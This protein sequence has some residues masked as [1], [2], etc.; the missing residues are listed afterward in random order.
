MMFPVVTTC[1]IMADGWWMFVVHQLLSQGLVPHKPSLQNKGRSTTRPLYIY[2]YDIC[3]YIHDICV[4]LHIYI[5]I[6]ILYT[7]LFHVISCCFM[8]GNVLSCCFHVFVCVFCVVSYLSCLTATHSMWIHVLLC[9]FWIHVLL[10]VIECYWVLS[11]PC[12]KAIISRWF[13]EWE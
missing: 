5:Y 9:C 3:M 12:G 4:Y 1:R 10:S 2:I 13:S 6:Y 7:C 11:V 8:L